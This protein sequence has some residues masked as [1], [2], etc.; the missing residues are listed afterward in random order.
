LLKIIIAV[1][2][3]IAVP[4]FIQKIMLPDRKAE[5]STQMASIMAEA[6]KGLPRKIDAVTTLTKAEF[7]NNVY[8]I[9]YT[10]DAG[11]KVDPS[12]QQTYK[13]FAV[14]QICGSNMKMMLDNKVTIEYLYTFN[15]DGRGDQKMAISIPPDSCR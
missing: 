7:D 8:R 4:K 6:N 14:K 11:A 9:H 5:L 1:A 10:M 2:I 13:N 15:P 3:V 12:Q